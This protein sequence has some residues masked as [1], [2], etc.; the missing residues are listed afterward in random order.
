MIGSGARAR[1]VEGLWVS[2][3]FFRVLGVSP[4]RGR[5]FTSS[6]DAPGCSASVAVVSYDFWQ[7]SLGG[8]PGV[9]GSTLTIVDQP[10]TVVGVAPAGFR[11]LEVGRTFDVAQPLCLGA[12]AS[13]DAGRRDVW[14]LRVM[15]RLDPGWTLAAADAHLR[16][17]SPGLLDATVPEGYSAELLDRYRSFRFGAFPAGRGVS[18]LRETHGAS[19]S[20]LL[21]LTGL[22][23][24][25]TCG[26]LATLML[27]RA[28]ARE[29]EI[30]M[31]VAMGAPRRRL[32]SQMVVESLLVGVAGA[33][34]AIP[35]AVAAARSLVAFLDTPN[36]PISLTLTADWRLVAFVAG[37]AVLTTV[38]FGLVP[39]LRIS[40]VDPVAATRQT[41]RGLT[42]D[43]QR[44]RLQRGLVAAQ[45]A[46]SLVL[47]VAAALFVR[48]FRNLAAVDLGFDPDRV[49]VASFFDLGGFAPVE[50]RRA[51]QQE[52]TV[53]IRSAPGVAAAAATTHVLLSGNTWSHFFRVP[54]VTKDEVKVSRFSYVSPGYFAT[55]GIPIL[56]GREFDDHDAATSARVL[57]VNE[58]FARRHLGAAT[59]IGARLRTV[60]ELGYPEVSYEIV[61]L[62]GNTKYATLRDE[63]CL[64][65]AGRDA[66]PPIAYVP[67]AQDPNPP[68]YV[69]VIARSGG[70]APA[71]AAA[72]A[73]RFDQRDPG[74]GV[75]V[76]ELGPR[77][78]T[79]LAT[80]RAVAWLAGA[81]GVLAIVL[82]VVGLYGVIAYL[83]VSRRTEIGIRLALG[84][85]RAQIVGL[86]LRDSFWLLALGALI[87]LPLAIAAMRGA[88]T[89]LFG[90]SATDVPT[91]S[92]ATALLA[93]AGALAGSIPA[94]R[95]AL[96]P[97]MAAIRDEPESM[98]RTARVTVRRAVRELTAGSERAVAATVIND[99]AGAMHRAASSAD[100]AAVAL[101]TLRDRVGAR[102]I[103]LLERVG[104]EYQCPDCAIPARGVLINRLTHYPHPL[105]LTPGDVQAWREWARELRPEHAAEI[106]TLERG[107]VRMAVPLRTRN[108]ILG[109]LLLGERRQHAGFSADGEAGASRRPPIS[110]R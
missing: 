49:V 81:F 55:L 100:M 98:W 32:V 77:I 2:G 96:L 89:L 12:Q 17:I 84:S 109:V 61:G 37:A 28:G 29:R 21:G 36:N 105:P 38:L 59:A 23:L 31:R 52:V 85:T 58:S 83:A 13:A 70:P 25:I 33:V 91:L 99:V 41:S 3:D 107:G 104:D 95:A 39:A 27:A 63:D 56:A 54:G 30:A 75:Q 22:V 34:A 50:R 82:I 10:V 101:D 106:E 1:P 64:C 24:L 9:V 42:I 62:V 47:V 90:V 48:S 15:G 67:M 92:G 46:L 65:D 19:L 44:A 102:S 88:G 5:L 6:D 86:V 108:E 7:V 8:D 43:R 72:I 57:L 35:V 69:H 51:F 11:G 73:Q 74:V 16:A 97:P 78:R 18:R 20:L 45:I 76:A 40:L 71:L 80:E 53:A 26:N 87:G 79:L 94:F 110:S 4:A 60:A 66:M 14:W 103:R 68:A 93:L